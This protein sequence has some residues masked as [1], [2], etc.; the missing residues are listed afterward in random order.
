MRLLSTPSLASY[1]TYWSKLLTSL[2][3]VFLISKMGMIT[4]IILRGRCQDKKWIK[5]VSKLLSKASDTQ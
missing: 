2:G 3:L 5:N 4:V 1:M